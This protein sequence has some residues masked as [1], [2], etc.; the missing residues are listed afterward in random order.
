VYLDTALQLLRDL[1]REREVD[2]ESIVDLCIDVAAAASAYVG[3]DPISDEEP[4][5]R[6]ALSDSV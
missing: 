2:A 5:G 1:L 3:A 6:R 4:G